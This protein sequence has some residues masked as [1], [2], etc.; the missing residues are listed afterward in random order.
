MCAHNSLK[1]MRPFAYHLEWPLSK[2]TPNELAHVADR[3]DV[4]R[5]KFT[6]ISSNC[7]EGRNEEMTRYLLA[8]AK[9]RNVIDRTQDY[10]MA[11]HPIS[12]GESNIEIFDIPNFF[13]SEM[14]DK[15]RLASEIDEYFRNCAVELDEP[16][17]KPFRTRLP[18]HANV[19]VREENYEYLWSMQATEWSEVD[20]LGLEVALRRFKEERHKFPVT[21]TEL[22]PKF[23]RTLPVDPFDTNKPYKYQLKPDGTYLLYGL[24]EDMADHH[25]TPGRFA[26][27]KG[28]D[29]VAGHLARKFKLPTK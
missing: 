1:E 12:H 11:V 16:Y 13:G 23:L 29:L 24:G 6:P 28:F 3:L 15:Q 4:I 17:H 25:G 18:K 21:L 22:S 10:A 19:Y 7:A 20:L 27:D 14:Y 9:N 2:L 26:G 5:S 8:L